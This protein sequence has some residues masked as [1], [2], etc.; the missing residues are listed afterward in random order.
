MIV[1]MIKDAWDTFTAPFRPRPPISDWRSDLLGPEEK[2]QI[3]GTN[4]RI[5]QQVEQLQREMALIMRDRDRE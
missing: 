3:A 2:R 5:V 1:K 4:D